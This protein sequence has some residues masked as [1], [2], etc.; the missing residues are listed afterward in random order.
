MVIIAQLVER[1]SVEAEVVGA[2]PTGHPIKLMSQL[3]Q[4]RKVLYRILADFVFVVHLSLVL[5]VVV[6][7]LVPVLFYPF[8]VAVVLTFLSE[9]FFGFCFLSKIEFGLR[10]RIDPNKIFDKSCIAHYVRSL[11]GLPPR[12]LPDVPKTFFK[13]NKFS[14]ILLLVLSL[15]FSYRI[16]YI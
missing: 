8:L 4:A 1:R 5:L 16:F 10:K 6:G 13:K 9:L 14:F 7:W 15:G 3:S 11:F 12:S 2:E